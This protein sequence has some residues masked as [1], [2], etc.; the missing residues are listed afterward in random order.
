[1]ITFPTN[2]PPQ[3]NDTYTPF[4]GSRTWKFNGVAWQAVPVPPDWTDIVNKPTSFSPSAHGHSISEITSLQT[5]LDGKQASGNYATL[6]GGIVPASQLPSFVDDVVEADTQA[7][8]P[9][10]ET[11]KIYVDKSNGKTY[12]WGGSVFV[13]ISASPGSTDAVTEGANN[14]YYTDARASAA[15]PVQKVA[16][17]TGEVTLGLGDTLGLQS[18]LAAKAPIP[19]YSATPPQIDAAWSAGTIYNIGDIVTHG[20]GTWYCIRYAP[21]GYGPFGGYIDDYWTAISSANGQRWVDT[22]T[23]RSYERYNGAWVEIDRA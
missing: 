14:K 13:E 11:G 4:V 23:L 5:T 16:G 3:V 1:M 2:P 7:D 22:T 10:G 9:A 17:R 18:S 15:A 20:G 12:R 6:E 19:I 21:L 8:F